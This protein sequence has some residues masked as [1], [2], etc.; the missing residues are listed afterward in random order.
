MFADLSCEQ[1]EPGDGVNQGEIQERRYSS[2]EFYFDE[3]AGTTLQGHSGC[4][5]D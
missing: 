3:T 5:D 2:D 4:H 1:I